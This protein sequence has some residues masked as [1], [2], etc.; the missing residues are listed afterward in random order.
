MTKVK[1]IIIAC[2]FFT[3]VNAEAKRFKPKAKFNPAEVAWISESGTNTVTGS[4][5]I[6]SSS[7]QPV[8]CAGREASL[9]PV[10]AFADE[11][12]GYLYGSN[13]KGTNKQRQLPPKFGPKKYERMVADYKNHTLTATCDI[14]GKFMFTDVPDGTYYLLAMA[15]WQ[16]ASSG[17]YTAIG[18]YFSGMTINYAGAWHWT[19]FMERLEVANGSIVNVD[20]AG[21]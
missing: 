19:G 16:A 14:D 21:M 5:F 12:I 15:A 1:Y 8:T 7:G 9:V 13:E 20:F 11:R 17:G 18:G 6:M 3:S 10:S 2:L 4:A